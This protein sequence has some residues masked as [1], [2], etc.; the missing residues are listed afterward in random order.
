MKGSNLTPLKWANIKPTFT[1]MWKGLVA[2][3]AVIFIIILAVQL[4]NYCVNKVEK[5][6]QEREEQKRLSEQENQ[7]QAPENRS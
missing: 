2:I 5:I 4:V 1:I 6:K 3:F 7:T